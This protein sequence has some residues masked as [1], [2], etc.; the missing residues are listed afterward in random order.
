MSHNKRYGMYF[1]VKNPKINQG[2]LRKLI[3]KNV[4]VEPEFTLTQFILRLIILKI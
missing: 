3:Y 1:V 4:T 2:W